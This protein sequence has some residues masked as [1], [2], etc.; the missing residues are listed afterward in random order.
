MD[1]FFKHRQG[2][3]VSSPSRLLNKN[4]ALATAGS[5]RRD[6]PTPNPG[7]IKSQAC[8][9]TRITEQPFP[10]IIHI[11]KGMETE[12]VNAIPL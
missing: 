1:T 5:S 2:R 6:L 8:T 9:S 7:K 3:M 10:L 4:T 12:A 11:L